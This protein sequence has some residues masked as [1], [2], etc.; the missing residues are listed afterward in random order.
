MF[1]SKGIDPPTAGAGV[2]KMTLCAT[3]DCIINAQRAVTP[4]LSFAVLHGDVRSLKS[5]T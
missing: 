1:S 2:L 3:R 4:L 5:T